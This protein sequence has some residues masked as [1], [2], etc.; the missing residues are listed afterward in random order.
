[1]ELHKTTNQNNKNKMNKL[2]TRTEFREAVFKRDKRT[3]CVPHCE[4][5]AVD[6]HHLIERKLW[7]DEGYYLDNGAS[8]CEK[9]HKLAEADKIL[10]EQLRTYCG[11]K[12]TSLPWK[13]ETTAKFDKWGK[14]LKRPNRASPKYP[15]TLYSPNSYIPPNHHRDIGKI[16]DLVGLPLVITKKMD[17]SNTKL[18]RQIVAARNG[19]SADH[20]SFDM[21]KAWHAEIKNKIPEN[22][23]LFGEWLYAKHSIHYKDN[24]KLHA[25][26]QLFA[27]YNTKTEM[28]QS[29][30]QI[31]KLSNKIGCETVP[32]IGYITTN[33]ED[34]FIEKIIKEEAQ[35]VISQGHEGIIIRSTFEFHHSQFGEN[36]M[37]YVRPNHVQT[38]KHWKDQ[39]ITKNEVA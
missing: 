37:K 24:L 6:A 21:L 8:L 35:K 23:D 36:V 29:W 9:H 14:I 20:K 30:K 15:T 27:A 31:E 22:L 2:L 39:K 38:D 4:V 5:P 19:Q 34:W 18:N 12:T 3:C 7:D 26:F 1:M 13:F 32:V 17:G 33:V 10:P 25:Y 11:I 28:W 16:Q